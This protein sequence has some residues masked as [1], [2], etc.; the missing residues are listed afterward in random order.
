MYD[1]KCVRLLRA[2]RARRGDIR[3]AGKGLDPSGRLLWAGSGLNSSNDAYLTGQALQLAKKNA[4]ALA[5]SYR[6]RRLDNLTNNP[7]I[8]SM[9]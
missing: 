3:S 9:L 6:S 4:V 7:A 5:F 8:G 2:D 1:A